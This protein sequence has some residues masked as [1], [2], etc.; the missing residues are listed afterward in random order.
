MLQHLSRKLSSQTP[1]LNLP[2]DIEV[3][4]KGKKKHVLVC[5]MQFRQR[6]TVLSLL[7]GKTFTP[8]V[9]LRIQK[10]INKNLL[11]RQSR[12]RHA[13]STKHVVLAL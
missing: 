10:I 11:A 2:C 5:K 9:A 12:V 8:M 3:A 6:A 13:S 1:N 7:P 4:V